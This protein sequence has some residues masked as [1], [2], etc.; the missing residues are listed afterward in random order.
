MKKALAVL[1]VLLILLCLGAVEKTDWKSW[2]LYR[3]LKGA[4]PPTNGLASIVLEDGY[5]PKDGGGLANLRI[6][7]GNGEEIP[8]FIRVERKEES[9]REF[10]AKLLENKVA[11][12]DKT[13][14]VVDL[15]RTRLSNRVNLDSP[16]ENFSRKAVVEG[17]A[18]RKIWSTLLADGFIFDVSNTRNPAR[19]AY[20]SFPGTDVRYLRITIPLSG[21]KDAFILNKVS[22]QA[23]SPESGQM[24]E[25]D[26]PGNPVKS[27]N[28][29]TTWLLDQGRAGLPLNEIDFDFE[30]RNFYRPARVEVSDDQKNWSFLSTC[31]FLYDAQKGDVE[32]QWKLSG[33]EMAGRYVRI[34]V[35]DGNDKP[36]MVRKI[37]A[38]RWRRTLLFRSTGPGPFRLYYG[39]S[40]AKEPSYDLSSWAARTAYGETAWTAGEEM[41]NPDYGPPFVPWTDRPTFI[42][43]LLLVVAGF[44][45]WMLWS[46]FQKLKATPRR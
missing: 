44:L 23:Y 10:P 46:S 40:Q 9:S 20:L 11:I 15:G 29:E 39:N 30:S 4:V 24:E 34:T 12:G 3:E 6:A 22:V 25:R 14:A 17:S 31:G 13:L 21:Q 33:P 7:G 35:T 18:D 42:W 8:Y 38:K 26:F 36:L 32:N 27:E 37:T 16:N 19:K 28:G 43:S 45:G 2:P 1:P 5:W 41:P